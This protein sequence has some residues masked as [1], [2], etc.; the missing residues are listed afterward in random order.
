M[1]SSTPASL[2]IVGQP[3]RH[4]GASDDGALRVGRCVLLLIGSCRIVLAAALHQGF[5]RLG[6]VPGLQWDQGIGRGMVS[7]VLVT[8]MLGSDRA[9]VL[10][11]GDE[12]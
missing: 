3:V 4:R 9:H 7:F 11:G 1:Q 10:P 5:G 6:E 8:R 12:G 2:P